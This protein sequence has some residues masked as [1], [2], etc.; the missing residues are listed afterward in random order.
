MSSDPPPV[1]T[2]FVFIRH[3][4]SVANAT[5]T[6][7]GHRMCG[8][9]TDSGRDQCARL[10]ARLGRT[11]E[12]VGCILYA[13]HFRR[14]RETAELIA[15]AVGD[16]EVL[17][18]EGFGEIDWG[19]DCDGLTWTELVERHGTPDWDADPDVS[20]FPG[21]ESVAA[22]RRRVVGAIDAAVQEHRGRLVVVCTHGGAIDVAVRHAMGVAGRNSFDLYTT[23]ASLTGITD[24][25]RGRWRIDRYNDAAHL[26]A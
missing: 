21:G 16:P 7:H 6:V 10:A 22:L 4:E 25:G 8:G 9:L 26:L 20:F 23:N 12:L 14:A 11:G 15:P 2:R 18:D 5:Q 3:G 24:T 19:A 17:V 13:S 1:L